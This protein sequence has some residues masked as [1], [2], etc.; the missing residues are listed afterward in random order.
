MAQFIFECQGEI[1]MQKVIFPFDHC[2]SGKKWKQAALL[3]FFTVPEVEFSGGIKI[4][5]DK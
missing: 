5:L 3:A 2:Y 4:I 1:T